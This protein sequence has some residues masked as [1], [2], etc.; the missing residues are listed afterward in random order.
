MANPAREPEDCEAFFRRL[1]NSSTDT[2]GTSVIHDAPVYGVFYGGKTQDFL[3]TI[4]APYARE[5]RLTPC[6]QKLRELITSGLR[7]PKARQRSF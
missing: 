4:Y 5:N 3:L 2:S 7:K 6:L 1:I